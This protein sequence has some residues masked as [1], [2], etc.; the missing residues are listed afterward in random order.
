PHDP[1]VSLINQACISACSHMTSMSHARHRWKL[2]VHCGHSSSS[3]L[4]LFVRLHAPKGTQKFLKIAS[5]SL[6]TV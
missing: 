2:P 6:G 1:H 3:A 5:S 4:N